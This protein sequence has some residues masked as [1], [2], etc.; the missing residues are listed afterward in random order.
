MRSNSQAVRKPGQTPTIS[1]KYT[2]SSRPTTRNQSIPHQIRQHNIKY[3]ESHVRPK[4]CPN[5]GSSFNP[6]VYVH[7]YSHR[8]IILNP[9]LDIIQKRA[10]SQWKMIP[11]RNK[12][13]G[14]RKYQQE[15]KI[16]KLQQN[17]Y[18]E[19]KVMWSRKLSNPEHLLS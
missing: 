4:K 5:C 15:N 19:I 13:L 1:N 9:V 6:S 2:V 10:M 11:V 8:T 3:T 17:T 16:K 7:Y 14:S 18:L 12:S